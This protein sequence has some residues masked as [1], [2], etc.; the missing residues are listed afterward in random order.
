MAFLMGNNDDRA[1]WA[2]YSLDK[3]L[4]SSKHVVQQISSASAG[5]SSV[6]DRALNSPEQDVHPVVRRG[7]QRK[8]CRPRLDHHF[9]PTEMG[10]EDG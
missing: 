9:Q 3:E 4:R 7:L 10:K 5:L 8:F 2:R 1:N 6:G